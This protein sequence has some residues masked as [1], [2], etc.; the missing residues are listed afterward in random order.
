MLTSGKVV[1]FVPTKDANLARIF[2]EEKLGLTLVSDNPNALVYESN[3][4]TV[5]VV[6]VASHTPAPFTILGWSVDDVRA[7]AERLQKRGVQFQ[8]YPGLEQDEL[9]IW[10]APDGARVAWF[11]DPDGNVL[12]I[13]EG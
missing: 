3:G 8:R 2:Y 5:R 1:G 4:T 12:S 11:T 13:S 9:G 6:R 10:R 7:C